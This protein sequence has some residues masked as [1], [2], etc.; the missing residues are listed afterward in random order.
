MGWLTEWSQRQTISISNFSTN[1]QFRLDLSG[2]N[3]DKVQSD[4]DD[5]RVT[6]NNGTTLL[7]IWL[8]EF[9]YGAHTGTLWIKLPASSS[10]DLYLY[11]GNPDAP[12][13][14]SGDDTFLLF[15]HFLGDSLDTDKWNS[16]VESG[17]SVTVSNS[18]VNIAIP[19]V[20]DRECY[21]YDKN[22]HAYPITIGIRSK[23]YSIY[24]NLIGMSVG[25]YPPC[26]G[27]NCFVLGQLHR[28]NAWLYGRQRKDDVFSEQSYTAATDYANYHRY[29][30]KWWLNN[31]QYFRDW[32]SLGS[33]TTNVPIVNLYVLFGIGNYGNAFSG[34]VK[35]DFVYLRKYVATEP[36][37]VFGK[38]GFKAVAIVQAALI[39]IPPLIVLPT[40]R[41]ILR[42]T[43]G[44]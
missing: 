6:D 3:W 18:E 37:G 33:A 23:C 8:E 16:Y 27:Y 29:E 4:G 9:D 31:V 43:G 38:V 30:V 36:T 35:A 20:A 7:K 28:F 5:I 17:C 40:L 19:A 2:M 10:G 15:D 39:S 22:T 1:C 25:G 32:V 12:S 41:E 44:C 34:W 42:L 13:V 24:P 11:T 14:S 21:I 26:E